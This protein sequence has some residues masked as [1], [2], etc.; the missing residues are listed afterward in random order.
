MVGGQQSTRS[1]P[2]FCE[3]FRLADAAHGLTKPE[4]AVQRMRTLLSL[5]GIE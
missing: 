3:L 1:L 2:H 5:H 4:L